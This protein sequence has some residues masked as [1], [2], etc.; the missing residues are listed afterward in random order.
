MTELNNSYIEVVSILQFWAVFI[1]AL[2][3]HH[4]MDL[5][6]ADSLSVMMVFV[7]LFVYLFICSC[8][9]ILDV[10]ACCHRV[11]YLFNR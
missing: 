7:C 5:T 9:F 1:A 6:T 8:R 4:S 10:D 11:L 3:M 2:C